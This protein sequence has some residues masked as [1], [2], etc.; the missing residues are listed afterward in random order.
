MDLTIGKVL[1]AALAL[2][3]AGCAIKAARYSAAAGRVPVLPPWGTDHTRQPGEPIATLEGW[4]AATLAANDE[5]GKLNGS[6]AV[7]SAW[8]AKFAILAAGVGLLT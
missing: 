3:S 2:T 4:N 6:A 5:A 8:S 7:W 1:G